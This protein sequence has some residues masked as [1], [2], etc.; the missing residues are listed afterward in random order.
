MPPEK[1]FDPNA[2]WQKFVQR[3]EQT[4]NALSGQLTGTKEFAALLSQTGKLSLLGQRV[5]SVHMEKVLKTLNL[6]TQKQVSE[7][8]DQLHRIEATLDTLRL[9]LEKQTAPSERQP[10]PKRTLK[11]PR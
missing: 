4:I 10:G 8:T 5:F 11:P 7:L 9:A 6:P 3:S 1:T 2:E